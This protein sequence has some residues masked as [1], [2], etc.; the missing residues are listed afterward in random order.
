[1]LALTQLIGRDGQRHAIAA[2]LMQPEVRL[3]TLTGPGGIGKTSLALSIAHD[4]QEA[5]A[6]GVCFV[7]LASVYEPALVLL[8]IAEALEQQTGNRPIKVGTNR[9]PGAIR[10]RAIA[11]D[12]RSAARNGQF[13]CRDALC[14]RAS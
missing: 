6:D 3:I 5:F 10:A 14:H 1:P 11:L 13:A 12:V 9:L 4:L 2:L 8:A 7:P